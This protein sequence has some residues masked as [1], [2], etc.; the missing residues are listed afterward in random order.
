[1]N[2]TNAEQAVRT[3]TAL[4]VPP[5]NVFLI[6]GNTQ[7]IRSRSASA[8]SFF[9]VLSN[10]STLGLTPDGEEG[11]YTPNYEEVDKNLNDILTHIT[12]METVTKRQNNI[13]KYVMDGR[14]TVR[15]L[16]A[17]LQN[18]RGEER[19][20]VRIMRHPKRRRNAGDI[21]ESPTETQ[22]TKKKKTAKNAQLPE[23]QI[24]DENGC[25]VQT[26]PNNI[27]EQPQGSWQIVVSRK[28]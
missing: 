19:K 6:Q 7:D 25:S 15:S 9:S 5:N 22:K 24:L 8:F 17:I 16:V 26:V 3:H 21:P 23:I 10:G 12:I 13:S 2:E 14:Q 4:G 18:A 27:K 28:K 20:S 11:S 1:M